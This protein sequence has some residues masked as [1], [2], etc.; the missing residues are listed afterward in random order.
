MRKIMFVCQK[1]SCRSQMAEGFALALDKDKRF[2]VTSAGL[3]SSKVNPLTIEVMAEVGI[4]ISNHKSKLL[5]DFN[6]EE[7]DAVA[8]MCGCG[9]SLP[10]EWL[11]RQDFQEWDLKDPDGESIEIFRTV[12]D[13]VKNQ[14]ELLLQFLSIPKRW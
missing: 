10:I 5:S 12:R 4:N 1:N 13:E 9:M 8:S 7:F 11:M 14:V 3:Q 6:P 2:S